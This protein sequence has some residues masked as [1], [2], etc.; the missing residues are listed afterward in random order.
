MLNLSLKKK[1]LEYQVSLRRKDI[2]WEIFRSRWKTQ[3]YLTSPKKCLPHTAH[4]LDELTQ[5]EK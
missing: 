2:E 4:Y 1:F 5:L 3:K